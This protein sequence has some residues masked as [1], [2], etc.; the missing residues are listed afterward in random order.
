L[1]HDAK[2]RHCY[3]RQFLGNV[4]FYRA[5]FLKF[6][7]RPNGLND[8]VFAILFAIKKI[9]ARVTNCF[10]STVHLNFSS[11]FRSRSWRAAT[12]RRQVAPELLGISWAVSFS[13]GTMSTEVVWLG[14]TVLADG[15]PEPVPT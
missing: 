12:L 7:F 14:W 8:A 9:L 3:A 1:K 11:L 6:Y 2:L 4:N 15:R 5:D 13:S 10:A